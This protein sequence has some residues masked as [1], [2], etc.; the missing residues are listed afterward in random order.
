MYKS[1]SFFILLTGHYLFSQEQ[2]SG[3]IFDQITQ[4]PIDFAEVVL[5]NENS[6]EVMGSITNEQGI[7][8]LQIPKG[9][10]ILQVFYI[11][12]KL[13]EQSIFVEDDLDLG[14]IEVQNIQQLDE[15]TLVS[16]KKTIQRKIDRLVF[17]VENSTKASEGDA[18]EV[19]QVT[20]G[21]RVQNDRI[22][23]IGKSNLQV[24]IDDKIIRLSGEELANFLKSIPSED[25]KMIEV[26]S[27]PPAKYEASGNSGLI[28]ITT[29]KAN[30][31]S[32][33]AQLQG[34]YRQ[35]Y[36]P[37]GSLGGSFNLNKNKLSISSSINYSKGDNIRE[38][39]DRTFFPDGEWYINSS[40][41]ANIER[42]NARIDLDYEINSSWSMGGQYLYSGTEYNLVDAPTTLV[43]NNVTNEILRSLQSNGGLDLHPE[44]HSI[45][46]NNNIKIDTLG[47]NIQINLDHFS[48]K[49]PE[50][51]RYNGIS[52]INDPYSEQYFR[53]INKNNQDVKNF[54]AKIDVEYPTKWANISFGGKLSF[55]ES[56]ND[57]NF[58]NSGLVDDPVT[59]LPLDQNDFEYE[60]DIQS[61]YT[62]INKKINDKWNV[63]LGMRLEITRTTTF[64]KNLELDID[65]DYS[66]LFPT[67]YLSHNL[68]ESS[69]LSFSYSKRI[70]RPGFFELNPNIYYNSP[71]QSIEGNAFLQPAFIDN[72]ELTHTYKNLST[73]L[74]Y[75]SEDNLFAQV[76]LPNSDTNVIRVTNKNFTDTNR[77]GFSENYIFDDISWW[78]SNNSFD[79]NYSM[80][81]FDLEQEEEDRKGF[82]ASISTDNDIYLNTNKNLLLGLNFWYNFPGV[83]GIFDT[84]PASSLSLSLQWLLFNKNMNITFRANDIFKS[85]IDAVESRV[86]GVFQT[87]RYYYDSRYLQISLSYKFGNN[88]ISVK[89]HGTGN[90]QEKERIL[91]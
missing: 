35:R 70:E 29:K 62:S 69:I 41:K 16:K 74:Y 50:S 76:P 88:D 46:Y 86:N 89:K 11:G 36:Y 58:F 37:S 64:S 27:T 61:I 25:I 3:K 53:G 66:K 82:R 17:N 67:M 38:Q 5:I 56:L 40:Y 34:Y 6:E 13:I 75:S 7:F 73:K 33:N 80:S 68:S 39:E 23:M 28:N 51:R 18:L 30:K 8:K 42:V 78:S 14:I 77:F 1:L 24:M 81:K 31:D 85:S 87:G 72:F 48:Y 44:L 79:L 22:T 4:S 65:N 54:S 57:M 12:Q 91:N 84:K 9:K 60:E 43:T 21:V 19:L 49:N 10:Y 52:I 63:Q 71:F 20:P 55:S 47:K 90:E 2:L 15:V 45:N 32:W 26:I 59:D 83:D